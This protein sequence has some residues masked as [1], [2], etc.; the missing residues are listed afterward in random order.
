MNSHG[1]D[2]L[3][4]YILLLLTSACIVLLC[5]SV[6]LHGWTVPSLVLGMILGGVETFYCLVALGTLVECVMT[7]WKDGA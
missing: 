2:K 3:I 7:K 6:W 4:I 5:Y 1:F